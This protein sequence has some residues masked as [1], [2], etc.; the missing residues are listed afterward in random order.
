MALTGALRLCQQHIEPLVARD[1]VTICSLYTVLHVYS[2]RIRLPEGFEDFARIAEPTSLLFLLSS[3]I[4]LRLGVT[5]PISLFHACSVPTEALPIVPRYSSQPDLSLLNSS[6]P[7]QSPHPAPHPATSI[8]DTSFFCT[9]FPK[10]P[11]SAFPS[12]AARICL[13]IG[14][15]LSSRVVVPPNCHELESCC[16]TSE[17]GPA[18][19][20]LWSSLSSSRWSWASSGPIVSVPPR[21]LPRSWSW[22]SSAFPKAE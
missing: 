18:A 9:P 10:N 5:I 4:V 17:W 22:S 14:A 8:T 1:N 20:S 13:Q 16:G 2:H 11:G 12:I 21:S 3:L 15:V 6:F 19:L 7:P